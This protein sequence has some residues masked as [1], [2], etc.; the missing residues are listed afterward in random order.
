VDFRFGGVLSFFFITKSENAKVRRY[1]GYVGILESE[2]KYTSDSK[3]RA[4]SFLEIRRRAR[5]GRNFTIY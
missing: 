3:I 2:H 4:G 1:V 5:G